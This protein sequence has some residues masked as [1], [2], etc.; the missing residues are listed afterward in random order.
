MIAL[1]D[2]FSTNGTP[3]ITPR[4]EAQREAAR[5]NGRQSRGPVSEAG[6]R[7]S[8]RNALKHGLLAR[9]IAPPGGDG[10]HA[11][12]YRQ[13]HGE[14]V[15]EY[16]PRTFTEQSAIAVMA[17]DYVQLARVLKMTDVLQQAQLD[18]GLTD[19]S[20]HA[21]R[22]KAELALLDAA[23]A[24]LDADVFEFP[25]RRARRLAERIAAFVAGLR[26]ELEDAGQEAATGSTDDEADLVRELEG[27]ELDHLQELATALRRGWRKL[28]DTAHMA[29]L[30][31]GQRPPRRGELKRLRLVLDHRRR[32]LRADVGEQEP[33]LSRIARAEEQALRHFAQRPDQLIKLHGYRQR[34]ERSI[35]Q[36]RR[37]LRG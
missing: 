18:G 33:V 19:D 22:V 11:I 4:T 20:R 26:D 31:A 28:A 27:Q 9:K 16:E 23:L 24:K 35:R 17:R 29:R 2:R 10:E 30:F 1:S 7:R 15:N 14:L 36:L 21:R 8:R 32:D 37:D 12:L 25:P 6:K 3:P 13:I 34:I 5:R